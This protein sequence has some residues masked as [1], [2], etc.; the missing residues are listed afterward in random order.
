MYKIAICDDD[1]NY[2]DFIEKK[3][4]QY[5]PENGCIVDK[6][7][8][9]KEF[10][11]SVR[12]GYSLVILDYVLGDMEGIDIARF[13]RQHDN[14]VV[15][16][17]CTGEKSPES[18]FFRVNPYRYILKSC[19]E[20]ELSIDLQ[21]SILHMKKICSSNYITIKVPRG[22][23]TIKSVNIIFVKKVRNGCEIS[24]YDE[25]RREIKETRCLSRID[26]IYNNLN[27]QLMFAYAS[28]SYFVNLSKIQYIQDNQIFFRLVKEIFTISRSKK[29]DFVLKYMYYYEKKCSSERIKI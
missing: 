4:K 10:C 28:T 17:F 1:K 9:G 26:D 21:D 16:I 11:K 25:E 19:S 5:F 3:V 27:D 2:A 7:Y 6:Y 29:K 8:S 20:E 13:I 12:N 14:N 24:Y 23:K 15:L 18:S 22:V